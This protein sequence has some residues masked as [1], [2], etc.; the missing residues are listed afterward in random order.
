MT[1]SYSFARRFCIKSSSRILAFGSFCLRA[2]V[3]SNLAA[4]AGSSILLKHL[5]SL[6]R[7]SS[8]RL[9]LLRSN[10][11]PAAIAL[12]LSF[13]RQLVSTSINTKAT[14]LYISGIA[15][16]FCTNVRYSSFS[17]SSAR[18][19]PILQITDKSLSFTKPSPNSHTVIESSC[20]IASHCSLV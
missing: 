19:S 9:F 20:N 4:C 13:R 12:S 18:N 11:A 7:T 16:F 5:I 15:P 8:V 1:L 3:S 10:T 2:R 6:K 14:V 17:P